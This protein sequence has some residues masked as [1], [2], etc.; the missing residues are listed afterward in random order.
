MRLD[1]FHTFAVSA[2][3]AAPDV[4]SAQPWDRGA[5]HL[6]GVHV[7]LVTGA[8]FWIGLT[9]AAA[10]GDKWVGE[11]TPVEGDRPA[12]VPFPELFDSSKKASLA[13]TSCYFAAAVINSG[14]AQIASAYAFSSGRGFG[15]VFHDEAKGFARFHHNGRAGQGLGGQPFN[16]LQ[17]AV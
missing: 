13:R 1:S 10:P 16:S 9:S 8:Q 7:T 6:R 11:E 2:L 15:V 12:E 17:E 4:Q 14:N 5:E 3:A